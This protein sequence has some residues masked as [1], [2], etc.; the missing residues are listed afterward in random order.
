[1]VTAV[2]NQEVTVVLN[3]LGVVIISPKSIVN[4]DARPAIHF[5]SRQGHTMA[6]V[7]TFNPKQVVVLRS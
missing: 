7:G 6:V 1:M 2:G 3:R 4:D 5:S